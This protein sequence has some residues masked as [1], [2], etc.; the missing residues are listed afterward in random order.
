MHN[1]EFSSSQ[2]TQVLFKNE[3]D[4]PT[5]IGSG[6]AIPNIQDKN[7]KIICGCFIRLEN[8]II[9]DSLNNDPVDLI[10]VL[11]SPSE[12]STNHLRMLAETSR[13][14]KKTDIQNK[15]RGAENKEALY[16]I[17]TQPDLI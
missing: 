5:N 6:V 4:K 9:Y 2:L 10:F 12:S 15:L 11:L 17:L 3:S 1:T 14:L 16:G 7:I 13:L 8:S